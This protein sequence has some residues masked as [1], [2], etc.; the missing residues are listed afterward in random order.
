MKALYKWIITQNSLLITHN[1]YVTGGSAT[2]KHRCV[3]HLCGR[4]AIEQVMSY[5]L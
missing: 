3:T 4:N 5:E 1:F 2:I